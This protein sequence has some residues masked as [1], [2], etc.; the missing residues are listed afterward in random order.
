MTARLR[1]NRNSVGNFDFSESKLAR[2]TASLRPRVGQQGP[3][4]PET[5]M[6]AVAAELVRACHD[7]ADRRG[8]PFGVAAQRVIRERPELY[9]L[10]RGLTVHDGDAA[11]DVEIDE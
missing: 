9:W 2:F 1:F 7:M 11:A 8:V 5:F 10:S 3:L 4:L 6:S